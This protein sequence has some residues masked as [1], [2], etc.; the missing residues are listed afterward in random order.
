[1]LL[2]LVLDARSC[3]SAS[4]ESALSPSHLTRLRERPDEPDQDHW[5]G[6]APRWGDG[7]SIKSA[8]SKITTPDGT[9]FE[10]MTGEYVLAHFD[11]IKS[12]GQCSISSP[13]L[14]KDLW[15]ST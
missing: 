4:N 7:T 2:L 11:G 9:E 1:L 8:K 15:T 3:E 10:E 6:S 5:I 14:D 13:E 12:A